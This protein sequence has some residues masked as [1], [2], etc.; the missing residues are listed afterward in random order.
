MFIQNAL[1]TG[2]WYKTPQSIAG[3]TY[4]R[5]VIP[6]N[7]RYTGW[8][9]QNFPAISVRYAS[10]ALRKYHWIGLGFAV[11]AIA[12]YRKQRNLWLFYIVPALIAFLFYSCYQTVH[13][14]YFLRVDIF[15][16]PLVATG[17]LLLIKIV[18]DYLKLR[19]SHNYRTMFRP[20]QFEF[21][22]TMVKIVVAIVLVVG[23]LY[24]VVRR[25]QRVVAPNRISM[26]EATMVKHYIHKTIPRGATVLSY[27]YLYDFLCADTW[28]Q[29][30]LISKHDHLPSRIPDVLAALL[31]AN[32]HFLRYSV[33][34]RMAA[35]NLTWP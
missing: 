3:L 27:R 21:L 35:I 25:V 16:V 18:N 5:D 1:T 28:I 13:G 33:T 32:T 31:V 26:E 19:I 14:R 17:I 20:S 7:T 23:A 15:L 4:L 8:T 29:P 6:E 9:P 10:L 22:K 12:G 24:P 34:I 30:F 2:I 11:G